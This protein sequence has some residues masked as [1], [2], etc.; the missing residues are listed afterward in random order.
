MLLDLILV[1][2]L[3]L[4]VLYFLNRTQLGHDL[5]FSVYGSVPSN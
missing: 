1:I 5:F 2:A 4:L 3:A